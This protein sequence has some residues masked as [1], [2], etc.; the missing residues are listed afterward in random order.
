[1]PAFDPARIYDDESY[2]KAIARARDDLEKDYPGCSVFIHSG[3]N[4]KIKSHALFG[5]TFGYDYYVL[6]EGLLSYEGTDPAY[7]TVSG[8]TMVDVQT[9][10]LIP[11]EPGM[12]LP[13]L[14]TYFSIVRRDG[15]PNRFRRTLFVD[16]ANWMGDSR[17]DGKH[18]LSEFALPGTHNS[19][20]SGDNVPFPTNLP[21]MK[22]WVTY[23]LTVLNP[24]S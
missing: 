2:D 14:F 12:S 6:A 23:R 15:S 7:S 17:I 3:E 24:S 16:P 19:H 8:G 1:M 9:F 4:G 5:S 11:P 21:G 20:A 13:R 18:F 22:G 10:I